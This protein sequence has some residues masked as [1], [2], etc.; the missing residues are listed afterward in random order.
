M[1]TLVSEYNPESGLRVHTYGYLYF[2]EEQTSYPLDMLHRYGIN[3]DK[4]IPEHRSEFVTLTFPDEERSLW[5][6]EELRNFSIDPKSV[7]LVYYILDR[8]DTLDFCMLLRTHRGSRPL[9]AEI[10]YFDNGSE[11]L[12]MTG[13]RCDGDGEEEGGGGRRRK[14]GGGGGGP[15]QSSI[16]LTYS[17][18]RFLDH[19]VSNYD[20]SSLYCCMGVDE[21][22]EVEDRDF[23]FEN[24]LACN[25]IE[26]GDNAN[27]ASPWR[28]RQ[29][30]SLK[31]LCFGVVSVNRE[32][33]WNDSARADI[34]P[35]SVLRKLKEHISIKN[36]LE[37][38]LF[39]K[40]MLNQK[41]KKEINHKH[42]TRKIF[43][44]II[45]F[46]IGFNDEVYEY[47]YNNRDIPIMYTECCGFNFVWK[48]IA[49]KYLIE[50]T[51]SGVTYKIENIPTGFTGFEKFYQEK[52]KRKRQLEKMY[53]PRVNFP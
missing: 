2:P 46:L 52:I 12:T 37:R 23:I 48:Y 24:M 4:F 15:F 44:N 11:A 34:L 3:I 20:H 10:I 38:K 28:R 33:L 42:K 39:I 47:Y 26:G 41:D 18:Q 40:Y 53:Y 14:G 19:I 30:S 16:T 27:M 13:R 6:D 9:Y 25:A 5:T 43:S 1:L 45:P 21:T 7:D 35:V 49:D 36:R 29:P 8:R 17:V 32:A 31:Q 50:N 22:W 51:S